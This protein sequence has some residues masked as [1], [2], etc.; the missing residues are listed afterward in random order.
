VGVL[1]GRRRFFSPE[2]DRALRQLKTSFPAMSWPEITEH[3]PGFTPRQVRERWC[4]YLSPELKTAAWTSQEDAELL[5]LHSELGSR[6]GLIGNCM[7]NRS[8]PDIKNR[9][10]A[11][12]RRS[13]KR[14]KSSTKAASKPE[15]ATAT[16]K[17]PGQAVKKIAVVDEPRPKQT[18]TPPD[19]ATEFLIQNILAQ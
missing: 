9:Y 11:I 8:A 4:N 7:G 5:R 6:W 15:K 3:M 16:P 10:Q 18:Q 19:S 14:P 13:R 17:P 1:K 12:R 2:D